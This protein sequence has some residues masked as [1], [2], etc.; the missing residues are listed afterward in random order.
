MLA[1]G[2]ALIRRPI[3][4]MLDGPSLGLAPI[5]VQRVMKNIVDIKQKFG[6]SVLLVEQNVKNAIEI[7][8]RVYVLKIG[9]VIH[10]EQECKELC[11][12]KLCK[13]F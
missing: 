9:T 7:S 13:L 12:E 3:L 10:E 6:V 4:L 1:I 5:L 8:E 2:M 11:H